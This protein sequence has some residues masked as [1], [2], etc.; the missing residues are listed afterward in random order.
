MAKRQKTGKRKNAQ[1][2]VDLIADVLHLFGGFSFTSEE[3]ATEMEHYCEI[4]GF[5][6][7]HPTQVGKRLASCGY[8]ATR[9][10]VD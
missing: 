6:A 9:E 5:D 7:P 1:R 4:I 3:F 2:P 10:R 8:L